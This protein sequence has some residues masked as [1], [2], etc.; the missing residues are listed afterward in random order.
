MRRPTVTVLLLAAV[1]AMGTILPAWTAHADPVGQSN[2]LKQRFKNR[3]P[4]IRNLKTAGVIG[5]NN[6]GKLVIRKQGNAEAQRLVREEN[7]DRGKV[8]ADIAKRT[9][10]TSQVVGKRR[11]AKIAQIAQKGDWLQNVAG[12]WYRK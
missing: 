8:Y 12:K 6:L 10:T 9:N 5:E 7:T 1:L 11:A 4:Q 3:K 2:Q